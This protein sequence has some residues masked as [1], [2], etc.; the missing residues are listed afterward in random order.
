MA[1]HC[2][3]PTGLVAMSNPP[4]YP[5]VCC[6]CGETWTQR[7][8]RVYESGH[9]PHAAPRSREMLEPEPATECTADR[10][11]GDR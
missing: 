2:W 10:V 4:Q 7:V 3:H 6:H 9:G 5:H 11:T 1:K 8:K